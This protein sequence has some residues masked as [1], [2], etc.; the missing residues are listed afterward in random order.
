MAAH[1]GKNPGN[2]KSLVSRRCPCGPW[3]A[4]NPYMPFDRIGAD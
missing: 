2:A 3:P 1:G 4:R